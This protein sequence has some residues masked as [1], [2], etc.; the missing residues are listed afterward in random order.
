MFQMG[1]IL[2]QCLAAFLCSIICTPFVITL[3]KKKGFV[4]QPDNQQLKIH[5]D[6][7]PNVGGVVLFLSIALT[8][9]ISS[10]FIFGLSTKILGIILLCLLLVLLAVIDDKKNIDPKT[11]F[12]AH[13]LISIALI[14]FGYKIS[15]FPSIVL[16]YLTTGLLIVGAINSINLLDGV[17]GLAIGVS[18]ISC[19][20]FA[21]LA[22]LQNSPIVLLLS[23][24]LFGSLLGLL[25]YNFHPAKIFLGDGGSTLTG[26]LLAILIISLVSKSGSML[27][28]LACVTIIGVPILDTGFAIVR[29]ITNNK[30]IFKGDREHFYDKLLQKGLSQKETALICYSI[31]LLCVGLG[32]GLIVLLA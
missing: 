10:Y 27:Y 7:I 4:D 16:N 1:Y 3:A 28:F 9:P 26:L 13:I 25:P 24:V 19:L 32:L 21:C 12:L 11:R 17:D 2:I 31:S 18:G 29:R 15:L 8:L 20:A 5:Q 22:I 23:L 14:L 6:P 30:S